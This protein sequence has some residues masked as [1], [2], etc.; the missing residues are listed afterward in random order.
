MR[1][2]HCRKAA[3]VMVSLSGNVALVCGTQHYQIDSVEDQSMHPITSDSG[4]NW[5]TIVDYALRHQKDE[6][7]IGARTVGKEGAGI[8]GRI[9]ACFSGA[10]KEV[11]RETTAQNL[12]QHLQGFLQSRINDIAGDFRLE[13]ADKEYIDDEVRAILA[14]VIPGQ[15]RQLTGE[16]IALAHSAAQQRLLE[17]RNSR[18]KPPATQILPYASFDTIRGERIFTGYRV[19]VVEAAPKIANLVLSGGGMKGQAYVPVVKTLENTGIRKD[20]K[21]IAGTSAGALTA[22]CIATGMKADDYAGLVT[23]LDM[24]DQMRASGGTQRRGKPSRNGYG[25]N[26]DEVRTSKSM[27]GFSAEKMLRTCQNT[28][29]K[30]VNDF[31]KDHLEKAKLSKLTDQEKASVRNLHN[32]IATERGYQLTFNDLALL[33]KLDPDNFKELTLTGFNK[34]EQALEVFDAKTWPDLPI[35]TAMRISMAIPGII[36]PV[37]LQKGGKDMVM[38]DGGV[39]A[40][41]PTHLV[42]PYA[43]GGILQDNKTERAAD[44]VAASTMALSFDSGGKGQRALDRGAD[45]IR[46]PW[47]KRIYATLVAPNKLKAFRDDTERFVE[48]GLTALP[49][50]NGSLETLSFNAGKD[51]IR[52]THVDAE[53][54]AID[55]LSRNGLADRDR[56]IHRV[57]ASMDEAIKNIREEDLRAFVNNASRGGD[58]AH[59]QFLLA[60]RE[61]L[62]GLGSKPAA[63]AD[64]SPPAP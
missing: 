37:I 10:S 62:K 19:C 31:R 28:L 36:D 14:A 2:P 11:R 61:H 30:N 40:N 21:H 22:A 12:R 34:T 3:R 57:Y 45:S 49:A 50:R 39:N 56:A 35:A 17:L 42:N 53:V 60:A 41:L 20:L 8:L 59:G 6:I 43:T 26:G 24:V 18:C 54:G 25:Q 16:A 58:E 29:R 9:S 47:Y 13:P 55:T 5:Q 52:A 63:G 32:C 7:N 64:Q 44:I 1:M 51:V 4:R 23:S 46:M 27:V 33:H 15:G 48:A 38:I